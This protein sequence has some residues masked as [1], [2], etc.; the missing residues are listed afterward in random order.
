MESKTFTVIDHDEFSSLIAEL[1]G[2]GS[3]SDDYPYSLVAELS[4]SDARWCNDSSH[5]FYINENPELVDEDM[6]IELRTI[7]THGR[8]QHSYQLESVA[9]R[10]MQ[11]GKIPWSDVLIEVSW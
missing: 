9:K 3:S 4:E 7:A 11:L 2:W 8:I 1:F 6:E 10:L 5:V